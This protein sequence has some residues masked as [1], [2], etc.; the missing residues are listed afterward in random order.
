MDTRRERPRNGRPRGHPLA[1]GAVLAVVVLVGLESAA[2]AATG[3][4]RPALANQASPSGFP[5]GAAIFDSATL[6]QGVNPTGSIAFKLYGPN[7]PTCSGA[8]LWMTSTPVS[9]NGYYTSPSFTANTAGTYRWIATYNGD[10]NN[11]PTAPTACSDPAAAVMVGKRTPT[12]SARA[13]SVAGG[14]TTDTGSLAGGGPSGPTG[15]MTFTLYGP[16]NPTC[17]GAP[18]FTST[19]AVSGN[20][21]YTSDPFTAAAGNYQW[22]ARYSG[23]ANN[24]GAATTCSDP[25]NAAAIAG[26]AATTLTASP[27]SVRPAGQLTAAW[28]GIASPTSTDWV[29]LYSAGAPD[30]AIRAWRY[31]TGATSGSV[32]LTVPWG[33]PAGS[34]EMRLFSNNSYTRLA[35]SSTVTVF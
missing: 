24:Y 18:I 11:S 30:S 13:G 29:A 8:P 20:G 26:G 6:G 21:S 31:T 16:S 15:T 34:Y 22:I 32:P 27:T 33:T 25:A 10:A 19:K 12:L 2:F 35:T 9:G 7:D 23:D 1:V 17:A 14:S 28:S 4:A 3:L 5:V